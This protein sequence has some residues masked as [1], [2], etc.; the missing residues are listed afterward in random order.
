MR[1]RVDPSAHPSVDGFARDDILFCHFYPEARRRVLNDIKFEY[2]NFSRNL[3]YNKLSLGGKRIGKIR[4]S[5][6]DGDKLR[7]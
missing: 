6:W 4:I 7:Y 2:C 5:A 1:P 3:I